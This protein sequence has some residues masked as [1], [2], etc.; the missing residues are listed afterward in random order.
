MLARCSWR[1]SWFWLS[2]FPAFSTTST[3][4]LCPIALDADDEYGSR[5]NDSVERTASQ[6]AALVGEVYDRTQEPE[7]AAANRVQYGEWADGLM[8]LRDAQAQLPTLGKQIEPE[9]GAPILEL[10]TKA[11]Q[12]LAADHPEL[13][14][15]AYRATAETFEAL[16]DNAHAVEYYECAL[17]MDPTMAVK[18]RLAALR[19]CLRAS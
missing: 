13:H 12:R 10:L 4:S 19:K 1:R 15:E 18:K 9:V 2:S 7:Q 8:L 11:V 3:W 5:S 14:A 6:P 17:Q 16:G